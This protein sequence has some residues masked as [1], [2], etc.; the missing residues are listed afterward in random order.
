MEIASFP[1]EGKF[2]LPR[3]I[4]YLNA[5]NE[6]V[7]KCRLDSRHRSNFST[8]QARR[9]AQNN[10]VIT[11][12]RTAL[13]KEHRQNPSWIQCLPPSIPYLILKSFLWIWK[14]SN[15]NPS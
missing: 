9:H 12:N 10:G 14:R 11:F 13:H 8:L 6:D 7:A 4:C 1:T 15:E 5:P 2:F 3:S